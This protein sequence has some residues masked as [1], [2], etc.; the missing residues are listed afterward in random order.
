MIAL[1]ID[2]V[3]GAIIKSTCSV[4]HYLTVE[5]CIFLY[6]LRIDK[7]LQGTLAVLYAMGNSSELSDPSYIQNL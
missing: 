2:T 1:Y 7:M 5:R 4:L 6:Q 3:I